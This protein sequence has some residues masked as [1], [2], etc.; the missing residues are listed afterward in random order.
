MHSCAS[1]HAANPTTN[2][3]IYDPSLPFF[4]QVDMPN[5]LLSKYDLIFA[6]KDDNSDA[7]RHKLWEQ[8]EKSYDT[9]ITE[10]E[11]ER[12][13]KVRDTALEDIDVKGDHY[14]EAYLRRE[15]IFLREKFNPRIKQGSIAW[16]L[17]KQFW[18]RYNK[19][20]L[21]VFDDEDKLTNPNK[22]NMPA[23]D[24]RKINTLIRLSEASARAHRRN[25]VLQDDMD[26]AINLVKDCIAMLIPQKEDN[27][28]IFGLAEA[29]KSL[30][31]N[32]IKDAERKYKQDIDDRRQHYIKFL[33][34]I[35][36]MTFFN[37]DKCGGK[38]RVRANKD[39]F[40]KSE[41]AECGVCKGTRGQYRRFSHSS[42]RAWFADVKIMPSHLVSEFL[43][44]ALTHK[45]YHHTRLWRFSINANLKDPRF[46]RAYQ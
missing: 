40:G 9:A 16:K 17:M 39:E 12:K 45:D 24:V 25:D 2:R 30:T 35:G 41:P 27:T 26:V 31:K 23:A 29:N 37:C 3:G 44:L 43:Q 34:T 36:E 11:S 1:L 5:Y 14:S 28:A 10:K 7:A 6:L 20:N 32:A 4:E 38:G 13:A 19:Q 42:M 21:L 15:I 18:N 22:L 46:I 33:N 8:I